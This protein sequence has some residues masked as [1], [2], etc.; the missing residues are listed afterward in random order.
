MKKLQNQIEN[1]PK[2]IKS[3]IIGLKI[4]LND[5][6][7]CMEHTGIYNNHL[8]SVLQSVGASIWLENSIQIKRSMGLT[9]GKNDKV[10]AMRIAQ[11]ANLHQEQAKLWK[12]TREVIQSLKTLMAQRS[13]LTKA[14]KLIEIPMN[15]GKGFIEKK[16]IQ[17]LKQSCKATLAGIK[18]DLEAVSSQLQDIIDSDEILKELFSYISSVPN[19][20]TI[21]ATAI[22]VATNEFKSID[23]PRKFACHAGVAPF[24]HTSGSSVKGKTRV[25]NMADK[26]L[27]TLFHLSA[28][29]AVSRPGEL[30]EYFV[31]KVN[32]GKNKMLVLNAIRN[33]L[34]HRVFAC[35]RDQRKYFKKDL[36]LA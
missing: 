1:T 16:Q 12:P 9:R 36:T 21:T 11:Y 23:N 20:G 10:D 2:K 14:K 7:F 24:E 17:L 15:E 13:R 33:K 35:V 4:D 34:I 22:L 27:K 29:S 32:T 28:L 31:R 6:L 5:C 25:S 30:R 3:F 26:D 18:K 19:V 8:L